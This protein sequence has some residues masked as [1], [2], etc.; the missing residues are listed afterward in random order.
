MNLET[1]QDLNEVTEDD[2]MDI[3]D[4]PQTEV[5]EDN[6]SKTSIVAII[7]NGSVVNMIID[8]VDQQGIPHLKIPDFEIVAIP[9][10]S[11][12]TIGYLYADGVFTTPKNQ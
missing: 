2:L 10:D 9:P 11:D 8:L 5:E 7:Q 3:S 6:D 12:V 1:E 4:D